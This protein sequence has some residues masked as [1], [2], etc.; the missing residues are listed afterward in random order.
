LTENVSVGQKFGDDMKHGFTTAAMVAVALSACNQSNTTTAQSAP[1]APPGIAQLASVATNDIDK[2][3]QLLN[4]AMTEGK[5]LYAMHCSSCHGPDLK[6]S[7]DKH[8]PDLTD[9]DWLYAGD[10][11]DT[12]GAIHKATDV[13]KTILMGIRAMPRVTNLGSQQENDAK[14]LESKNLA[15]MPAFSPKGEFP[16]S[17]REIADVAESVLQLGGQNHNAQM[18][19]RGKVIFEDKGSCYDCH[20]PEGTGD[21][22]IGS[23]NLTK[24][25]L[26]LYGST[27]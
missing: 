5:A 19:R 1:A 21:P 25:S 6:G 16:L 18:A 17:D 14:N 24:P 8:T 27:R 12:G 13:E 7:P 22:A 11:P 26:Y 9:N 23:T 10:D 15:D 3:P 2:N 4:L 20:E